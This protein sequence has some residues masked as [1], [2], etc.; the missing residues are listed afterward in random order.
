MHLHSRCGLL[1]TCH[2]ARGRLY[3]TNGS[4]G[5]HA[6]CRQGTHPIMGHQGNSTNRLHCN[7]KWKHI[8]LVSPPVC[9]FSRLFAS[10]SPHFCLH[11][12]SEL[13]LE[14]SFK[15]RFSRYTILPP[16]SREYLL[17][18]P[19]RVAQDPS[20]S[21]TQRLTHP[22][23]QHVTERAREWGSVQLALQE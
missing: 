20:S 19:Q 14:V 8:L 13:Q 9:L 21:L 2:G 4:A 5:T 3:Q 11:F 1:R 23:I 18:Q 12:P 6:A 10:P 16:W 17:E 22:S 7:G 15:L